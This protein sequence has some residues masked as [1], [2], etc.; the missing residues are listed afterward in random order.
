MNSYMKPHQAAGAMLVGAG[1][2][3]L[4]AA[5]FLESDIAARNDYVLPALACFVSGALTLL[6]FSVPHGGDVN[7]SLQIEAEFL[8]R[9]IRQR[10]NEVLRLKL[11]Y[12]LVGKRWLPPPRY[13]DQVLLPSPLD[14][15]ERRKMPT[16]PEFKYIR[17]S[18][19]DEDTLEIYGCKFRFITSRP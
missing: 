18:T 11:Y 15:E 1:F 3:I 9:P 5:G 10:S 13:T 2:A 7:Q 12:D 19:P 6:A 17:G 4:I 14:V 16:A 8:T